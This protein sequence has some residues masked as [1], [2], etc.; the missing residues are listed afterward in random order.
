MVHLRIGID[1]TLNNKGSKYNVKHQIGI[2]MEQCKT[3]MNVLRWSYELV[4]Y[5]NRIG[6][7][8]ENGTATGLTNIIFRNKYFNTI[9]G[10]LGDVQKGIIDM[11]CGRFRMTPDRVGTLNFS[12]PTEFEVNQVYLI[13][14]PQKSEDIGFLFR[15]FSKYVWLLLSITIIVVAIVF[16]VL[17]VV[18]FSSST[19]T[20]YSCLQSGMNQLL[21]STFNIEIHDHRRST[22]FA[23]HFFSAIWLLAWFHVFVDYYTSEL[24]GMLVVS[25][26]K[27][28]P[29]TD[30]YGLIDHL[31][32][33]TYRLLTTSGDRMPEC[34]AEISV[35]TC[36][37]LFREIFAKYPPKIGE[38][39]LLN[40]FEFVNTQK[41]PVVGFGWYPAQRISS[42]FSIWTQ[43]NFHSNIWLIKD[44]SVCPAAYVIRPKF[45]HIDELNTAIISM[46]PAFGHID[47]HY[48]PTYPVLSL[49]EKP[50]KSSF[51]LNQH[52]SV[53]VFHFF[54]TILSSIILLLEIFFDR[55]AKNQTEE[56]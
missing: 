45:K 10:M 7:V 37:A 44:F 16:F 26:K 3:L 19:E 28:V 22:F 54:A 41:V 49:F 25:D 52:S 51:T 15:P 32:K 1:S 18:E 47:N 2:E 27:Q 56:E 17:R 39:S 50:T 31:R 30:F 42:Q 34:P 38:N 11:A 29:F 36:R 46:M 8:M 55:L 5:H 23:F 13:S 40:N 21:G 4:R 48:T 9:L 53:F 33:G 14:D 20:I 43:E 35:S 6:Y 12:Y 24:S